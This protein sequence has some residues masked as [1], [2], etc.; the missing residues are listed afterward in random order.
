MFRPAI[1]SSSQFQAFPFSVPIVQ[2]S[3]P[4]L[5]KWV[6]KWL[7]KWLWERFLWIECRVRKYEL[8]WHCECMAF[9]RKLWSP[10]IWCVVYRLHFKVWLEITLLDLWWHRRHR[11]YL[12]NTLFSSLLGIRNEPWV[13]M[14][15]SMRKVGFI[16]CWC[17]YRQNR[18]ANIAHQVWIFSSLAYLPSVLQ[19]K[20]RWAISSAAAATDKAEQVILQSEWFLV[21]HLLTY[22]QHSWHHHHHYH[23][24]YYFCPLLLRL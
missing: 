14:S 21:V 2:F 19:G 12:K 10:K 24:H 9:F 3:E 5:I 13:L 23:L 18:I 8:W 22:H 20:F 4:H 6:G 7:E 15:L 1:N 17:S 11:V 16:F